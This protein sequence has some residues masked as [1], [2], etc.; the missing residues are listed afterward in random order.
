M[1]HITLAALTVSLALTGI[2]TAFAA[3]VAVLPGSP[4]SEDSTITLSASGSV[5]RVPDLATVDLSIESSMDTAARAT[6]DNNNRY[7]G[8]V[9]KVLG[10]GLARDAVKTTAYNLNKYM[11]GQ[12]NVFTVSRQVAIRVENLDLVGKIIDAAV[13]A[14][15]TAVSGVSYGLR[16]PQAAY[17]AALTDAMAVAQA[18]AGVLAQAGHVRIV[19]IKSIATYAGPPTPVLQRSLARMSASPAAVELPTEVLPSSLTLNAQVSVVFI[20]AP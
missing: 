10:L 8:L 9:G 6:L 20:I 11:D 14:N 19:R 5:T 17:R 15:V 2:G 13:A 18:N 16:D 12:K 4:V 7:N 3:P 1:K